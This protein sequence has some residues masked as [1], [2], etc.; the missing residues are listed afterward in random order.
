MIL[1]PELVRRAPKLETNSKNIEKHAFECV[2]PA[3][4]VKYS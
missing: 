3:L 4:F 1:T 2:L